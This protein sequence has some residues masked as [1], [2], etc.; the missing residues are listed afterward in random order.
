MGRMLSAHI[1]RPCS[2]PATSGVRRRYERHRLEE[3]VPYAVLER[4]HGALFA[5]L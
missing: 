3:T 1:R 5:Q 2:K 4:H